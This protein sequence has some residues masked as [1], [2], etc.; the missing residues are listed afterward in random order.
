MT[1]ITL[2]QLGDVTFAGWEIPASIPFGGEQRL[3]VHRMPGGR[4]VIDSMGPDD[5]PLEWEGRFRGPNAV[6]RARELD[7]MRK[8]GARHRL[9]WGELAFTVKIG[10]FRADYQSAVEIP[11]RI[12][13]EVETDDGN[14]VTSGP[15]VGA[16]Q[17]IGGDYRAASA[18]ASRVGNGGLLGKLGSVGAAVSKVRDFASASRD[19]L[20]SVLRPI[21]SAQQTVSGLIDAAETTLNSVQ[22]LGGVAPGL[23]SRDLTG[24]LLAQVSAMSDAADLYDIQAFLGRAETNL[25]AIGS[26]GAQVVTAGA[27]LFQMATQAYGDPTEWA[28]IAKAN[29]LTDPL[30]TGVQELTIPPNPADTGGVLK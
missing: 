10:L 11:Y 29:G 23:A 26:S 12:I 1:V 8:A 25:G 27:D 18:L 2:V 19:T 22:G 3:K 9:T 7:T 24:G 21:I 6:A 16:T 28:T 5:G 4:R 20:N 14:P 15:A 17:M 30:Q 13:C